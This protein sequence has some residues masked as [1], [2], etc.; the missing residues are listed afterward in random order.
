M[1]GKIIEKYSI[2]ILIIFILLVL[3]EGLII[4]QNY[5][6]EKEYK[7]LISSKI[8]SI[9]IETM[10]NTS[11]IQNYLDKAKENSE[12]SNYTLEQIAKWYDEM[13]YYAN[14]IQNIYNIYKKN[15]NKIYSSMDTH[16]FSRRM[17]EIEDILEIEYK[18]G[19]NVNNNTDIN[20]YKEQFDKIYEFN[21][22][23]IDTMVRKDAVLYENE[24]YWPNEKINN[25][26]LFLEDFFYWNLYNDF[27]ELLNSK[28]FI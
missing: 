17:Y 18:N 20:K 16:Y 9:V 8:V 26:K 2:Q 3:I 15:D 6:L 13:F 23:F 27:F 25:N 24:K 7:E 1:R 22:L 19:K 14:D 28:N 21:S 12:I 4:F 5:K 10:E 11:R